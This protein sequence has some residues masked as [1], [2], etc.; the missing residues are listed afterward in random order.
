MIFNSYAGGRESLAGMNL[1]SCGHIFAKPG[2]EIFRPKGR[3]DFLLFF[4]ARGEETFYFDVQKTARA[5]DFILYAPG[6]KQH[7]ATLGTGTAEFYYVHF[8][9]D[10]LPDGINMESSRIYPTSLS[11]VSQI[12]EEILSETLEKKPHYEALCLAKLLALF[13]MIARESTHTQ[14]SGGAE[15]RHIARA[16]QHIGKNCEKNLSLEEYAAMCH[17]SKYHFLRI[18]KSVTGQTPIEYR[19]RIRIE[20]AKE[21]LDLGELSIAEIGEKLGFSSA[22]HFSD[23]FK[24]NTG[25]SPRN[26][27]KSKQLI[28]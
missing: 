22:A 23:V 9:C 7:H 24:K 21:M 25:F 5:G 17:M 3:E 20:N 6:E 2:R 16:I 11:G 4:V 19:M 10:R 27:S 1:V 28:T 12:F 15:H 26:Y 8:R 18:F 13:A 14:A